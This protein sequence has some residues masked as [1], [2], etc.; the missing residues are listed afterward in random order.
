MRSGPCGGRDN[1]GRPRVYAQAAKEERAPPVSERWLYDPT[2]A[3]QPTPL[4]RTPQRL[5]LCPTPG[6][7]VVCYLVTDDATGVSQGLE[8]VSKRALLPERSGE[9]LHYPVRSPAVRE[10]PAQK[11]PAVTVY[12]QVVSSYFWAPFGEQRSLS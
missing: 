8:P 12:R 5:P 10:G 7:V 1:Q 9:P 11:L 4:E 6:V 3:A 2:E